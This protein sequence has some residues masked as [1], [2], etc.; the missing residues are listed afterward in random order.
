MSYS[1]RILEYKK[2]RDKGLTYQEIGDQL[3]V[4]RQAV[5][6]SLKRLAKREEIQNA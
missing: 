3:G 5:H 2:L 6:E 1:L 4:S